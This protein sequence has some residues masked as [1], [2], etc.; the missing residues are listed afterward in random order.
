M[1]KNRIEVPNELAMT[2]KDNIGSCKWAFNKHITI[3]SQRNKE[4]NYVILLSTNHHTKKIDSVTNKPEII[5][6]YNR[7]K[8][9][10]DTADKMIEKFT[11]RRKTKRWTFNVFCYILDIAMLNTS[12]CFKQMFGLVKSTDQRVRKITIEALSVALIKPLINERI[13]IASQQR[14]TGMLKFILCRYLSKNIKVSKY[15]SIK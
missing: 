4:N 15:H 5:M 3:V 6:H 9:G 13:Q 1:R 8:G 12:I 14:Y 2:K 11:C 10:I 7:N